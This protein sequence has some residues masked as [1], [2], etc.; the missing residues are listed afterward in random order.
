MAGEG[1][2]EGAD[3]GAGSALSAA[4]TGFDIIES[5]VR[6]AEGVQRLFGMDSATKLG[7]ANYKLNKATTN[8]NLQ[9]TQQQLR[10]QKEE[11]ERK[12]KIRN[13]LLRGAY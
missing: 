2:M 13:L 1:G 4:K 7:K 10:T 6:S 11:E 3:G 12:R 8:M 5:G 9:L